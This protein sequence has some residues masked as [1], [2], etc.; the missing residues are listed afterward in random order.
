LP[1]LQE[2]SLVLD[3]RPKEKGGEMI[4]YRFTN[5]SREIAAK[6][7]QDIINELADKRNFDTFTLTLNINVD[8]SD[9][10]VIKEAK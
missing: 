2:K 3:K 6:I 8:E 10:E 4:S 7:A 9:V 1:E 5:V